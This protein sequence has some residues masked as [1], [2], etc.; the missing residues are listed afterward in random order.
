MDGLANDLNLTV[1]PA[2]TGRTYQPADAEGGLDNAGGIGIYATGRGTE[3]D[4]RVFR[5]LGQDGVADDLL[6]RIRAVTGEKVIAAG[7]PAVPCA[8]LL[9]DWPRTRSELI[10]PYFRARAAHRST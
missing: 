5:K 2:R 9:R 6:E 1:K 10:E 7:Q 3:F 8:T 4:L